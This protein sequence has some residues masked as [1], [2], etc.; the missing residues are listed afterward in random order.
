MEGRLVLPIRRKGWVHGFQGRYVDLNGEG[1]PSGRK[2]VFNC[3]FRRTGFFVSP[4][5]LVSDFLA[6]TES[7]K[8]AMW[9]HRVYGCEA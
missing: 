8:N 3:G 7:A 5:G 1:C 4:P 2:M 6:L 9:L